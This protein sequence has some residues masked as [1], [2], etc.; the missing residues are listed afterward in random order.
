MN[1]K[2]SRKYLKSALK[3]CPFIF[4]KRLR[5]DLY[6]SI[7]YYLDENPKASENEL[8]LRFGLPEQYSAEYIAGLEDDERFKL[9]YKN[10]FIKRALIICIALVVFLTSVGVGAIVYD[11]YNS[12][13]Y[14]YRTNIEEI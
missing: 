4:K 2:I 9:L 10:R 5:A 6:N 7:C 14:Y 12:D 8:V 13:N 11:V 3:N 1:N